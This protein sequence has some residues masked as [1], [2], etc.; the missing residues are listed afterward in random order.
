[1]YLKLCLI[2]FLKL[3][4]ISKYLLMGK[5]LTRSA[6]GGM[7]GK[8]AVLPWFCKR[9]HGGA[10]QLP[11]PCSI[12]QNQGKT[13]VLLVLPPMAPLLLKQ[14]PLDLKSY[15]RRW[16]CYYKNQMHPHLHSYKNLHGNMTYANLKGKWVFIMY[17]TVKFRSED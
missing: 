6:I 7:T 13:A 9:E 15:L 2:Y 1:M 14:A 3:H 17:L 12:L 4:D 16:L 11:P 8:T 5:F 10:L